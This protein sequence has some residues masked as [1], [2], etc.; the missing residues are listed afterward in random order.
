[1]RSRSTAA[2]SPSVDDGQ[3]SDVAKSQAK[4]KQ[5]KANGTTRASKRGANEDSE[6]R[7][8]KKHKLKTQSKGSAKKIV[9]KDA[10]SSAVSSNG[11]GNGEDE[12]TSIV[13]GNEDDKGSVVSAIL[14]EDI[15]YECGGYTLDGSEW[16][17][18]ILC[19][20]CDGEYHLHCQ[21][22]KCM[23]EGSFMCNKCVVD[24]SFYKDTTFEVSAAFKVS[25][26]ISVACFPQQSI[27]TV[28]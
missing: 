13:S 18:V 4:P 24:E 28:L 20:L 26:S 7:Y 27:S 11:D 14:D 23:P 12:E 16:N 15:C 8:D 2:V 19:D 3:A 1:M 25:S 5:K 21:G 6:V 9:K 22:L 17:N 10:G